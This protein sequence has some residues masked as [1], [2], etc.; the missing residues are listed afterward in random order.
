[1]FAVAPEDVPAFRT[2]QRTIRTW[3]EIAGDETTG[4]FG[5]DVTLCKVGE[6]PA[7]DATFSVFVKTGDGGLL[8]I[9]RDAPVSE[10]IESGAFGGAACT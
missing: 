6:G 4:S 5:V 8:P 7:E 3:E 2:L 10:V 9:L 1:M